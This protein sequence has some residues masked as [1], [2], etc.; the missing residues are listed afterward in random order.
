M[1]DQSLVNECSAPV[2]PN[3]VLIATLEFVL[4]A[5]VAMKALQHIENECIAM[6]IDQF[7]VAF[8]AFGA[9]LSTLIAWRFA[10]SQLWT[11]DQ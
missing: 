6:S 1:I 3:G 7:L 4:M 9:S 10:A 5:P 11:E 2:P 8:L